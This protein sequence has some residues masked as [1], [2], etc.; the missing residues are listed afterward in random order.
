MGRSSGNLLFTF[1]DGDGSA[2]ETTKEK[3]KYR[4]VFHLDDVCFH[5]DRTFY[6]SLLQSDC[7]GTNYLFFFSSN[8][9]LFVYLRLLK[10]FNLTRDMLNH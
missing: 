7:S 6:Y 8:P 2:K 9:L 5:S 4:S 3:A 10:C 1:E